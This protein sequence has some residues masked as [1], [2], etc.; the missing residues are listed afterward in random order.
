MLAAVHRLSPSPEARR[1]L[2]RL[3]RVADA[4]AVADRIL[5]EAD[6]SHPRRGACG[7]CLKGTEKMNRLNHA[8]SSMRRAK[9][10]GISCE[11]SAKA[12]LAWHRSDEGKWTFSVGEPRTHYH[13]YCSEKGNHAGFNKPDSEKMKFYYRDLPPTLQKVI[14]TPDQASDQ[15]PDPDL[16]KD[17]SAV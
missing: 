16:D 12:D 7:P 1:L 17:L 11:L 8:P 4:A 9:V 10:Q 5:I 13:L 15:M 2:L 14:T 3:G 6:R